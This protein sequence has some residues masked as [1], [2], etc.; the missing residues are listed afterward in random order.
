VILQDLI[1]GSA[2]F[3]LTDS[4]N[5]LLL[6]GI[7]SDAAFSISTGADASGGVFSIGAID[8]NPSPIFSDFLSSNFGNPGAFS[9]SLT[10]FNSGE[11]SVTNGVLNSFT[12]SIGGVY[13][14]TPG[15]SSG[16]GNTPEPASL[17]LLGVGAAALMT[18]RRRA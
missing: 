17:A 4:S 14:S 3:T 15:G 8:Y 2:G 7:A 13:A 9:F 18:R 6:S 10:G 1:T 11:P 12:A 5:N 16:G